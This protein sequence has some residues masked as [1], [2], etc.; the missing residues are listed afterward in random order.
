[1]EES[2]TYSKTAFVGVW[3]LSAMLCFAFQ[4]M[5]TRGG[6][7]SA[8]LQVGSESLLRPFIEE[9]LGSVAVQTPSGH[10]GQIYFAMAHDLLGRSEIAELFD[11]N[12]RYRRPLLSAI[13]GIA[14]FGDSNRILWVMVLVTALS[15]GLIGALGWMIDRQ[16]ST[17]PWCW[18]VAISNF[19]LLA[20]LRGLT[21]DALAFALSLTGVFLVLRGQVGL[22]VVLFSLGCLA[23]EHYALLAFSCGALLWCQGRRKQAISVALIPPAVEL[24]WMCILSFYVQGVFDTGRGRPVPL[25]GILHSISLQFRAPA[26]E[27]F[28]AYFALLLVCFSI[29]VLL[30][31]RFNRALKIFIFPWVLLALMVPEGVW[32]Y[33]N[34]AIRVLAP[35]GFFAGL[36]F[37]SLLR[38]AAEKGERSPC[39]ALCWW[40]Q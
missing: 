20:S 27:I 25:I 13:A 37:V 2:R 17:F 10:D 6:D 21:P 40:S 32:S 34:N 22:S 1:M 23:K 14:G 3:L 7:L 12:Y 16:C 19:G 11:A 39:R 31:R 35:L 28:L 26:N 4:I 15:G 36:A 18:F 38:A 5:F 8:L 30:S 33:G 24:V 9:R 29:Y